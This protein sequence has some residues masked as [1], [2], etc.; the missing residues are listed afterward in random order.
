[1]TDIDFDE[2]DKAV[3]SLMGDKAV[4]QSA[5]DQP[6]AETADVSEPTAS[7]TPSLEPAAAPTT[8]AAIASAP[9]ASQARPASL[10]TKRRGQFMDVM[11]HSAKMTTGTRGVSATPQLSR[12][13]V[14]LAPSSDAI[15]PEPAADASASTPATSLAPP[16]VPEWPDPIDLVIEPEPANITPEVSEA[17]AEPVIEPLSSPFLPDAKVEKRPLG[18]A[19][20]IDADVAATAV[21]P[22][23]PS[24]SEDAEA[25]SLPIELSGGVLAVESSE[26]VAEKTP[27]S[28]AALIPEPSA[29]P[30][31]PA[32]PLAPS[33]APA[34][35]PV[36]HPSGPA[37]IPPQYKTER[38][39]EPAEHSAL[40]DTVSEA[41]G[42]AL[43]SKK[44]NGWLVPFAIVGFIILGCAG[45]VAAY[46]MMLR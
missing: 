36:V 1:M 25:A 32:V 12:H 2:L 28:D 3:N 6:V 22:V 20:T 38:T 35:E 30:Q 9:P 43:S 24:E 46:Y 41:H 14:S 33:E 26:A 19:P 13:G 27:E 8:S 10:A 42:A 23:P 5:P 29:V 7:A 40:Y 39:S 34:T 21:A 4:P 37:S 31:P 15:K 16:A 45:G 18:S 11:H 44:K 17:P